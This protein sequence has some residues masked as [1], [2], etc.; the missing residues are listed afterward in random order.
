MRPK[1]RPKT[2][3]T[4]L[5][6]SERIKAGILAAATREFSEKGLAGARVNRIASRT[7]SSKRMIY[8]YFGSKLGL[9]LTVLEKA[10]EHT[11][12]IETAVRA[13]ELAPD[14]ALRELVRQNFNYYHD[15]PGFVRLVMNENIVRA[16]D[17]G[18]MPGVRQRRHAIVATL[19]GLLDRGVEARVFRSNIDPVELHMSISGLCFHSAS[20]RHTVSSV[21]DRDLTSPGAV[22]ARRESIVDM[23]LC[24]CCL[25]LSRA[26]RPPIPARS[27]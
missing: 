11:S 4:G 6:A 22:A 17:V 23:V 2:A 15:N 3:G 1:S 26:M 20:N 8:Y 21:F 24:W 18:S 25:D 13:D 27:P 19:Q 10:Y 5:S 14:E 12:V 16:G 9:Y 7:E